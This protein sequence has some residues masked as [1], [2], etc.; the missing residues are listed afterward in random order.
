MLW[1][2]GNQPADWRSFSEDC[3]ESNAKKIATFFLKIIHSF[4]SMNASDRWSQ[5]W[6]PT[7]S[8]HN[9]AVNFIFSCGFVVFY[10]Q[11]LLLE[12]GKEKCG[13]VLLAPSW[14]ATAAHCL[15]HT[16]LKILKII[17]GK[18]SLPPFLGCYG[19]TRGPGICF[20]FEKIVKIL[21]KLIWFHFGI[22]SSWTQFS[23]VILV[24]TDKYF[25]VQIC[26]DLL[27][28]PSYES[29]NHLSQN[30][31]VGVGKLTTN[32]TTQI[33]SY[34]SFQEYDFSEG[35]LET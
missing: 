19:K 1:Y 32:P 17:L 18:D 24:A 11:A 34:L 20:S 10:F 35:C 2:W 9:S 14:V 3:K 22:R 16:H 27:L 6:S 7:H 29:R 33:C 25:S 21:S 5:N 8:P 28:A 13:G 23:Q 4:H 15:E 31:G 30:L 12:N 26:L